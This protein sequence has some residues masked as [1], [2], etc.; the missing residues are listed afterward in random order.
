MVNVRRVR[1]PPPVPPT[2]K[3]R[4][5]EETKTKLRFR[6]DSKD[7]TLLAV[8]AALYVVVN[9]VQIISVGNPTIFGPVQLRIADSLIA[10]SALFGVPAIIGVTAGCFLSNAYYS[11]GPADVVL[12]PLVNLLAA[13]LVFVLR[14]RKLVACVAGGVVVGI[15]VGGYL[16][17]FFPSIA[18]PELLSALP[19]LAAMI[20]SLTISSLITVGAIGYSLLIGLSRPNVLKPLESHGLKTVSDK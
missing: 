14:N 17:I 9:V 16:A 19:A 8:F 1:R 10:L 6:F 3:P 12:G 18:P 4:D 20:F 15:S 11:L 7:V 5:E 2:S 13:S